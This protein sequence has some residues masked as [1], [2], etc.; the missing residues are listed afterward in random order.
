MASQA[1]PAPEG[2]AGRAI[3]G[4]VVMAA[5]RL[6]VQGF[7]WAVSFLVARLLEPQDYGVITWGTVFLGLAEILAEAGIGRALVQKEELAPGDADQMFTAGLTLAGGAYLVLLLSAGWIAW[8]LAVPELALLLRVLGLTLL[9]VPVRTVSVALLDREQKLGRQAALLVLS[10]LVQS[11]L[12]LGLA[13][14]GAGFWALAAGALVS[15]FAETTTLTAASGWRP[16]LSWPGAESWGLVRFGLWASGSAFLWWTYSNADFTVVGQMFG[17]EMLGFY[18]LAFQL[19]TLPVD[20]L[21]SG[22]NQVAYPVFS[23]L[24]S[25]PDRLRDWYLR[26]TVMLGAFGVPALV[27]LALVADD[28][29]LVVLGEKW[30]PAVPYFRLLSLAGAVKVYSYSLPPLLNALGRPDLNFRYTLACAIV[31]PL[32]FL[33]GGWLGGVVGVCIAWLVLY[34]LMAA[35]LISLT[36]HVTGI[37]LLDFVRPQLPVLLSAALMAGLVWG[38]RWLLDDM[39]PVWRLVALIA[40]GAVAYTGVLFAVGWNTVVKDAL[41]MVRELRGGGAENA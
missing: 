16:R 11:S 32:G 33:V 14:Y 31:F 28:A 40:T 9:L 1:L 19:M 8:V 36:S 2:I 38:A 18:G 35:A 25:Q 7:A 39:V 10:S 13:W 12:V 5:A 21:T 15:K 22:V 20:R 34:P 3:R 29:F 4:G 17:K 30:L 23:R 26:L 41:A 37:G 27:G 6:L 24:Q